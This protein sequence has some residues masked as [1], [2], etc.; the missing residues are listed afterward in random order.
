MK[1]YQITQW[2]APLKEREIEIPA[3]KGTEVLIKVTACGVCHSD[4]H[5][6]DG[7]F[8]MGGGR[9]VTLEDRGLS[10]PFTVGHEPLGE[11]AKLGPDASGVSVGD[12]RV[13]YPWIGCGDCDVCKRDEELLC[14]NPITIGTRRDGGYAE[15]LIVPNAKYLVPYDGVDEAVAATAA[16]SGI[17]AYSALKK[18]SHL[19]A[20]ESLLIIGAG[21]V[22][23]A[24]VGM[25]KAVVDAKIIVAD[26]DPVKREA[27][28]AAGADEV[29][30]NSDPDAR[31]QLLGMTNG[32]PQGAIDFVGAPVTTAFGFSVLAKGASLVL[33]GLYGGAVELS[34]SL[35]PL[36]V[37]NILGSYV[38]T[39]QDLVELLQLIRE[40]KVKPVPLIK[41]QLSDAPIAIQELREGKAVGR[42][43]LINY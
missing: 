11:V 20:K 23:L 13:V 31:K 19:R 36:K 39:Q 16:C 42:F 43:V 2:G 28:L 6:W 33:V 40:G 35:F 15:Y 32:G 25:A 7:F 38:G 12:Q 18:Q 14:N 26:I 8:D 3:P 30:D 21:G 34:T 27:A 9:K 5:I 24:G 37:N 22:G 10:L 17:T 29:I 1:A 41:R 4:I